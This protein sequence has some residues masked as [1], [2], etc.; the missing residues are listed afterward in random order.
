MGGGLDR[1]FLAIGN[2]PDKIADFDHG[3]QARNIADRGFV[4]RDQAGADKGAGIDPGIGR[5]HHAAVQHAGHAHI[6]NINQF[7]GGLR[8]KIDAGH[9]L[10]NNAVGIGGLDGN[11]LGQ[12]EAD[13]LAG[14]Q[15]AVA[16]AAVIAPA[17]QAVFHRKVLLGKFQPFRGARDQELP[18]LCGRL[19]QRHRGD[20]NGL[21][22]DGGALIGNQRGIA[23]HDDDPRKGHVEFFGDDLCQRGADAGAEIDV[24][25]VG[26][27]RSVGCNLD[28]GLESG[29]RTRRCRANDRQRSRPTIGIRRGHQSR[30]SAA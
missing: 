5:A 17:D 3:D 13:D 8:R 6:V 20:L 14:N 28:E 24:P 9:R 12:F 15:F 4:D 2:D 29:C 19:A 10:P 23:Q 21:A 18:R 1:V 22:G 25:V 26:R 16:D 7:A 27:D 11:A 30:A